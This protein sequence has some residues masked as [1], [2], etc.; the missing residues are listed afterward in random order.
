MQPIPAAPLQVCGYF[1]GMAMDWRR[2]SIF[3]TGLLLGM[4]GM[5]AVLGS[6]DDAQDA[7]PDKPV[8]QKTAPVPQPGA[9][10][11][12]PSTN[13]AGAGPAA[14]SFPSVNCS[15][16]E[17]VVQAMGSDDGKASLQPDVGKGAGT[18]LSLMTAGKEA[19]ASGR[20]RDAE[21]VFLMACRTAQSVQPADPVL[22]A[23][24]QYQ[25]GRHYASAAQ[26][27][28]RGRSELLDRAT[29]LYT[30]ALETYKVRHGDTHEKT[31]FAAAGL[32]AVQQ[33][34]GSDRL[35][36]K[37]VKT[38]AATVAQA[39]GQADTIPAPASAQPAQSAKAQEQAKAQAEAQAKE[40]EAQAKAAEAQAKAQ[41]QA[42]AAADAQ[43]KAAAAAQAKAEQQ[44]KAAADAQAKAAAAA[45]AKAE[46]QAKAAADAQAKAAAA[47]QAK[48]EQ[49]AKATADAQAKA[50][51]A[52][53]A[54]AEQQA[55]A[56]ADA[57]AK[58]QQQAKAMA[59][60]QAR[61]A[62]AAQAKA[63]QQARAQADAQAKAEQQ[64]RAKAAA[65]QAR[66]EQQAKATQARAEQQAAA[67]ARAAARPAPQPTPATTTT[68]ARTRPSFDCTRARS[69][70]ERTIC[71]NEDLARADRELGSLHARAK[72]AAPDARAFQR[73][74]DAI[75]AQREASCTDAECLRQWY[76]RR[77]AEL[78]AAADV[79]PATPR[80]APRPA[81]R[82]PRTDMEVEV[83]DSAPAAASGSPYATPAN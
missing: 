42:R 80:P 55:R 41:Q 71:A 33:A 8:A 50:A 26:P 17:P 48:A 78:Q 68:A 64:A 51:A 19:A 24:A 18:A 25:L 12:A 81:V 11:A 22:V 58:A 6:R 1:V 29:S 75:W 59:D 7:K 44:A 43:A 57:Q 76:A 34:G 79:T 30:A 49:Q 65:E 40:A 83:Q 74:S 60:A 20:M 63:E 62:A 73:R 47:A 69:P 67:A 72:A 4:A 27:G 38:P 21:T 45:Q 15:A 56:A 16:L 3:V 52:A 10:G 70:A 23:D 5:V 39:S 31:R 53:Q 9:P 54:K 28:A 2:G 82:Q 14:A 35:L 36:A 66:A 61:A 37:S 13:V 32:E 77:R 46:Q